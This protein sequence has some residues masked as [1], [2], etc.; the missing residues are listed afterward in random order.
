[1][2]NNLTKKILIISTGG[3][4]AGIGE[5]GKTSQ[6]K[7][8]QLDINEMLKS[9]PD[10]SNIASVCGMQMLNIES[11][12]IT[13]SDLIYLSSTINKLAQEQKY[14]G[15]VITHGTDTL[16]ETA[17]FL[18]LTL[19]THK[20][21]VITGAMR[22]STATSADGPQNLYQAIMIACDK[23]S[24]GKGVLV[25]FADAIYSGRDVTKISTQCTNGFSSRDFGALGYI[26]DEY[27]EFVSASNKQHTKSTPFFISKSS[28]LENIPILYFHIDADP[29]LLTLQLYKHNAVVIAGAGNGCMSKL[30]IDAL[31]NPD[32][33]EKLVILTSRVS[34]G[35]VTKQKDYPS[36]CISGRTLNPQK[37]RILG[38]LSLQITDDLHQIDN[39]FEVF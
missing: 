15:F 5:T 27:I 22:P 39:Y 24:E 4:I 7:P 32:F 30:W 3:T 26:H 10:I 36:N 25:A 1:M 31:N 16:E 35:A 34:N 20:P 38:Q 23:N 19:K 8:A 18:N 17:Y 11:D 9:I 21:V 14:D 28:K 33:K 6:Y 2:F 12:D 37:A 13:T 29:S